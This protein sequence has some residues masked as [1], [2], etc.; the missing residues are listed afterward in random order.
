MHGTKAE[1]GVPL[2]ND[3]LV[4][5]QAIRLLQDRIGNSHLANIV[6][7]SGFVEQ[8]D[9]IFIQ[10]RLEPWVIAQM[11]RQRFDIMLGPENVVTG[12]VITYP[13]DRR[14]AED[15]RVLDDSQRRPPDIR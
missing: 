2:H 9:G 15:S 7:S 6:Q 14:Q 8:F 12:G 3:K 11:L 5:S 13:G 1:Q 4:I 10:L